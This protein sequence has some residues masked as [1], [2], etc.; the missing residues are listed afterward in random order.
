MLKA[1]FFDL[2]GTLLP[3][4]NDAFTK[5]YFKM[6]IKKL[7]P[8]GYE[9]QT[10]IDAIW[11]GTAAMV[12]NDGS[13][14]NYEAFWETFA[15][16]LGERVYEDQP[17]FEEFYNVDFNA[18]ASLCGSREISGRAVREIKDMGLRVILASNPIF[19]MQAQLNRMGWAGVDP[20]DFELITSYEESRYCK[21]N[22]K[23]YSELCKQ[24]GLEPEECLMV[25]NDVDEDMVA[26]TLG[27]KVF[28]LTYDMINRH[29]K[30]I[31]CYPHG[32]MEAALEYISSLV[33]ESTNK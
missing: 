12:R 7:A 27:M 1:V 15:A 21:P 13:R 30:P 24:L 14:T 22:P 16:T 28:L 8:R 26:Q 17:L 33:T 18:A 19:P 10:L 29:D 25:G 3:M 23:Y 2:D 4:D 31:D 32:T 9:G 20:A 11:T 6:L 5:G